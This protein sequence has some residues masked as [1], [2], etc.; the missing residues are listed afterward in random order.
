MSNVG[1]TST[2][3]LTCGLVIHRGENRVAVQLSS[4][5]IEKLLVGG[6]DQELTRRLLCALALIDED[7]ADE[8]RILYGLEKK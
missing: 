7:K 2:T 3:C 6:Y 5:E 8:I 1:H 4:P